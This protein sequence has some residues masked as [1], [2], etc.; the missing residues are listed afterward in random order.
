MLLGDHRVGVEASQ[1]VDALVELD[2]ASEVD[3]SSRRAEHAGGEAERGG[4]AA[5]LAGLEPADDRRGRG[6]RDALACGGRLA[7]RTPIARNIR[8]EPDG[9]WTWE[10][11]AERSTAVIAPQA[12]SRNIECVQPRA[13][14]SGLLGYPS[15]TGQ[16]SIAEAVMGDGASRG[17]LANAFSVAAN[18]ILTWPGAPSTTVGADTLEKSELL[19]QERLAAA[20]PRLSLVVEAT[21]KA[22]TLEVGDKT[23][24]PAIG[25]G[26]FVLPEK[27]GA[28]HPAS[29]PGNPSAPSSP[30]WQMGRGAGTGRLALPREVSGDRG[31]SAASRPHSG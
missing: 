19:I 3:G 15:V 24:A 20:D 26:R 12:N 7:A 30:A 9:S 6:D 4:D 27:E 16:I 28:P 31:E 29:S 21:S 25:L 13:L 10:L 23:E 14:E 17:E 22:R 5:D 11:S 1:L 18:D 2:A 8:P